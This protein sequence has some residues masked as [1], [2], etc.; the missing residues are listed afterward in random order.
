[1]VGESFT[2]VPVEASVWAQLHA[3]CPGI[4]TNKGALHLYLDPAMPGPYNI[5]W[6][7]TFP[8]I[9]GVRA[10]L[11]DLVSLKLHCIDAQS[12]PKLAFI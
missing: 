7:R 12:R 9:A 11:S 10:R 2:K 3:V 4:A 1:M 5:P 6:N 8:D